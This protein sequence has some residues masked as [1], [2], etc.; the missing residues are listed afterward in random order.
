MP[1]G[2]TVTKEHAGINNKQK[3]VH[4]PLISMSIK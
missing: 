4:G 2:T 3:Q 1:M